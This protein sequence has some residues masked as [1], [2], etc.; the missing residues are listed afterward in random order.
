MAIYWRN[1]WAHARKTIKGVEHREALETRSKR[2]AE[3]AH[4]RWV[5]SLEADTGGTSKKATTFAEAVNIFTEHHLPRLKKTSQV[6]YLQSLLL[7]TDYFEGKTLQGIGRQ[8]LTAF[9]SSRRKDG[10]TDSSVLRDLACLSSVFTIAADW[11]L[12][13]ANPVNA[14]VRA[15][16]RRK[17]LVEA[18]PR[19]RHLTHA[20]E[21]A[22]LKYAVDL[23]MADKNQRQ[24]D[25]WMIAR[26]I[27][28]YIDTGL[29]GQ[30]LL[31]MRW[32]WL[33]LHSCE[34]VIPAEFAK[35]GKRRVVPLVARAVAVLERIPRHDKTDLVLWRCRT[36]KRVKDLNHT[37][38]RYAAAVKVEDV[39]IH[40]LRR[41]A[42]CRMLQDL[43]MDMAAVSKVLG[44]SSVVMTEKA[45]AFLKVENLHQQMGTARTIEDWRPRLD[46]VMDGDHLQIGGQLVTLDGTKENDPIE[47]QQKNTI[48]VI[49]HNP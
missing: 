4:S 49:N 39:H 5:A 11:E 10:V 20:E 6:R 7:L 45:Y 37:F 18:G 36:G 29:R 42:G 22:V 25:K 8:D 35:S 24:A 32:S 43:R 40:D 1:G 34:I 46:A 38:Q 30:E 13:D 17:G 48:R 21:Y 44:H 19:E 27:C 12:I 16:K 14:Y 31:Q 28:L 33:N 23:A 2:E 3:S 26:A 47:I 41:T 15:Q 9:V